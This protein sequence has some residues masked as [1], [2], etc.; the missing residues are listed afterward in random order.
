ML[1]IKNSFIFL[2]ISCFYYL[3]YLYQSLNMV[4]NFQLFYFGNYFNTIANKPYLE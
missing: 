1:F 3:F 4:Y 2:T